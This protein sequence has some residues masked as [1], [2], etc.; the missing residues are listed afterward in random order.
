LSHKGDCVKK[1]RAAVPGWL[2]K[3]AQFSGNV[4]LARMKQR[5]STIELKTN[6]AALYVFTRDAEAF[7]AE[8]GIADGLLT[9]FVRHTSA[10]LVIQE[11]ADPDVQRD[12]AAFMERQVSRDERLYRHIAEGPD[13]M[14]SHI[15]SMLTQT[16]LSIPFRGGNLL[17]GTWQ[18]STSSSIATRRTGAKYCS[19]RW[20][21]SSEQAGFGGQQLERGFRP[22]AI[23]RDHVRGRERAKPA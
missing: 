18:G 1:G 7:V 20:G 11:N 21:N 5:F 12:L 6:G 9:C 10:S 2:E 14:P 19:T 13:D 4:N 8:S 15:R 22:G 3:P 16:S 17:L 23:M